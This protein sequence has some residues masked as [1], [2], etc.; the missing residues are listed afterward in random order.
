M[1]AEVEVS[2]NAGCLANHGPDELS[3][4]TYLDGGMRGIALSW[5]IEVA[6]EFRFHQETLFL[7]AGLVDRFLA[8]TQVCK[9]SPMDSTVE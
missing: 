9:A 4:H 3:L 1:N 7:A 6:C 2:Q 5:L 8:K